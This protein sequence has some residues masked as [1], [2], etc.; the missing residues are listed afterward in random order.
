VKIRVTKGLRELRSRTR[1]TLRPRLSEAARRRFRPLTGPYVPQYDSYSNDSP[2]TVGR[3]GHKMPVRKYDCDDC[4]GSYQNNGIR[5]KFT[6]A[7][8]LRIDLW[9]RIAGDPGITLCLQCLKKRLGRPLTD[10]DYAQPW[11]DYQLLPTVRWLR[12][13]R[14]LL[15]SE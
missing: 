6:L 1:S 7:P 14:R 4:R 13:L 12:R 2:W 11:W 15:L 5:H 9:K 3:L 10:Y 8:M